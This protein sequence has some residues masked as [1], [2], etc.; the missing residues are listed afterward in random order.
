MRVLVVGGGGREHAIAWACEQHGHTV[1]I[2]PA[3]A[4]AYRKIVPAQATFKHLVLLTDGISAEASSTT[5]SA[6]R[7]RYLAR[8]PGLRC[9]IVIAG[10]MQPA[11]PLPLTPARRIVPRVPGLGFHRQKEELVEYSPPTSWCPFRRSPKAASPPRPI[12]ARH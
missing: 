6:S 7:S 11:R 10:D 2:A 5:A 9:P 12:P 3:L 8:S 4:E 1:Q